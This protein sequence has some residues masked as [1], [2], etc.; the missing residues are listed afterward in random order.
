MNDLLG[1]LLQRAPVCVALA[2][3]SCSSPLGPLVDGKPYALASV[4]GEPLPWSAPPHVVVPI[5]DGW[6]Q[7]VDN[8][9][10]QRFERQTNGL[11]ASDWMVSGRY[12]L[13]FG[14]LIVD[15]RPVEP[16]IPVNPVDTFY[17]SGNGLVLRTRGLVAPL[18]SIIRYYARP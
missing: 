18:D 7:L 11:V 13:R 4:N 9:T 2:L 6:I 10:A 3:L 15:Y 14:V 8:Q 17:V 1:G 5:T 16:G 12:T